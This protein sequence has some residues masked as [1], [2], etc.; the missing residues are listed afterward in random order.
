[1]TKSLFRT[2]VDF[3]VYTKHSYYIKFD[4]KSKSGKQF[5]WNKNSLTG[6]LS[7]LIGTFFLF[8]SV[9]AMEP[10]GTEWNT[11]YRQ[12]VLSAKESSKH[13]LIYFYAEVDSP[14]LLNL[15]EERFIQS[16]NKE[17]RQVSLNNLPSMQKPLSIAAACRE[18]ENGPLTDSDVAEKLGDFVLLKIPIDATITEDGE[19]RVLLEK[20]MFAEM[21]NLPGLAILDFQHADAP[22]YEDVVSAIPFL[23]AKPIT[24]EQTLTLFALPPGTLT[25]RTLVYAVR[26]HPEKPLSTMGEQHPVIVKEATQ[27]SAYQAK[28]GVLGH[29]NFNARTGRIEQELGIGGASEVCAQSWPNEGLLEGAIGCVRAWRSSSGHWKAVRAQHNYY[30]YDMVRG[31]NNVWYATGLFVQ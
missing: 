23:R 14:K 20:P 21:Q 18:F 5:F 6:L 15:S 25:Q 2:D 9:G 13:L 16:G 31:R 28:T 12:A 30:G 19:E 7:L 22:Y 17:I 24:K 11:D 10:N 3:A 1:M 27:H 4:D 8:S 29:Q 26:I